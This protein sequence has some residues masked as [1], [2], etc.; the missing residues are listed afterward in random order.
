MTINKH[1]VSTRRLKEP[2]LSYHLRKIQSLDIDLTIRWILIQATESQCRH[3]LRQSVLRGVAA[4]II[5][6]R[7]IAPRTLVQI[8]QTHS[9]VA[10]LL[11]RQ[12]F[13]I[14]VLASCRPMQ[15]CLVTCSY[16]TESGIS[17]ACLL[18]SKHFLISNICS[19]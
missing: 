4:T 18:S 9:I 13:E 10:D 17:H 7:M 8:A 6:D 11:V 14:S 15:S 16:T 19:M 5:T 1:A 12:L 2:R 3:D